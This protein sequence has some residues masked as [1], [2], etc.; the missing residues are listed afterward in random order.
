MAA[1]AP[2]DFASRLLDAA[3]PLPVDEL[4]AK[5]LLAGVETALFGVDAAPALVGRYRVERRVGQGGG[6]TVYRGY[7]P[8]LRRPVAIKVLRIADPPPRDGLQRLRREARALA[9][10]N[11]PNVVQIYD[12]LQPSACS[13]VVVMEWVPARTLEHWLR[14]QPRSASEI[15]RAGAWLRPT[16]LASSTAI[17]SRVTCCW[18]TGARSRSRISVSPA[19][20]PRTPARVTVP[21]TL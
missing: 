9:R 13:V 11:H 16:S 2:A 21:T 20:P 6:G 18:G 14:E 4:E 15:L 5:L 10:L 1:H 19:A 17:S 8:R 7:D 3:G 12:V